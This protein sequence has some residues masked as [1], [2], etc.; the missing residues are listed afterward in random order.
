ME[1]F[2]SRLGILVDK[3]KIQ[4]PCWGLLPTPQ[5]E[6]DVHLFSVI[7]SPPILAR[8]FFLI[9]ASCSALP[10]STPPGQLVV[11]RTTARPKPLFVPEV[12]PYTINA[13]YRD[14]MYS[15]TT[16]MNFRKSID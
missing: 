13:D 16:E 10:L 14:Y 11:Q 3:Q 15:Q 4:T 6:L 1:T 2:R 12:N 7:F 9:C 8:L 5:P